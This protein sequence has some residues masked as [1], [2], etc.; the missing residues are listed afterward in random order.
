MTTPAHPLDALT[1]DEVQQAVA[2]IRAD[3][4]AEAD[5]VFVHVRLHEPA[6]DVVLA[7]EPGAPVDREVEALLVPPTR[8]EAIDVV[9]SVT[10]GA[11]WSW[12][13]HGGMRPALLFGESV[14][15]I[16]GVK[17]HPEWQAALRLRGIED[18]DLVQIDPWPAGSFGVEHEAGRRISRCVSYLRDEATDNGYARPIEGVIAFFDQ[19]AGEVL[20]VVDLGVVPI[21]TDRGAYLPAAVGPMRTDLKPLEIVQ[22]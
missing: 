16:V 14:G 7:Y 22:P 9:V 6:K 19:G 4:R 15:A 10:N 17:E 20:E 13:G 5:S 21:P 18:F 3:P 8:L 11:V 12:E 1:P 2:L